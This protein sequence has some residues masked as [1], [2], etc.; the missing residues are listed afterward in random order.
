MG[1]DTRGS[2]GGPDLRSV[3]VGNAARHAVFDVGKAWRRLSDAEREA[4]GKA[5]IITVIAA[6]AFHEYEKGHFPLPK[7]AYETASVEGDAAVLTIIMAALFPDRDDDKPFGEEPC[8]MLNLAEIGVR[9]C[10]GC[11]CTDD[12]ACPGGCSW[13]GPNLCSACGESQS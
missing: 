1:S 10:H 8:P 13:V 7:Q 5:A 12:C 9:A 3:G 11:G 6:V 4:V 2:A